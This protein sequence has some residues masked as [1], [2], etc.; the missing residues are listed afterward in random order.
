M[1]RDLENQLREMGPEFAPLAAALDAASAARVSR[2]FTGRVMAEIDAFSRLRRVRVA[3]WSAA[4]A[5]LVAMLAAHGLTGGRT[6][7]A[8]A[9]TGL[10]RLLAE[11]RS[12]G[13]FCD[14]SA[15]SYVQAYAV[16]ALADAHDVR[17]RA[18]L[19][20]AVEALVRSQ[21]G[22]GGWGDP[23][24]TSHN[25]AA[26]AAAEAAG[27]SGGRLARRRGLRYLRANG[28]PECPAEELGRAAA[29]ALDGMS[30]GVDFA[31]SLARRV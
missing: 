26:L 24:Q 30:A 4:A 11:Q 20:A 15:A 23:R 3:W 10:E 7:S 17:A 9:V 28:I 14:S 5:A 29:A 2:G 27:V 25:V 22:E 18:S 8:P 13:T 19:E 12:D 21:S 6:E 16:Q 31:T 1:T